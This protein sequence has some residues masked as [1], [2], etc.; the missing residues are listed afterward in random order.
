M[1]SSRTLVIGG[2]IMGACSA[3]FL[4]EPPAAGEVIVLERDPSYQ[5]ASTTLS[6]A[7]IRTQFSL[8]VNVRMSLFGDQFQERLD[9]KPGGGISRVRRGYLTLAGPE[10]EAQLRANHAM[11]TEEGA[12]VEWLDRDTLARTRPWLNVEDL[13]CGTYGRKHEGWCDAYALLRLT[14]AEAIEKGAQFRADEAVA[15]ERVGD[16]VVAVQTRSGERIEGD[17]VVIAAG[18]ASGRVAAMAGLALPVEPR[19]RTVF[20]IRTPLPTTDMPLVFDTSGAWIRPEGDGFLCGISPKDGEPDP[21]PGD[22]F[23]PDMGMMEESVWPLLAHRI[24]ALEELRVVR[25]WAGHYELCTLDH[26]AVIG[27]HPE[28]A[29]VIFVAG[30]SGHGVQHGPA[31]GRA[32]AEL[33]RTGG[34]R[35]L[36]LSALGY[37]RVRENR[38]MPE[39]AVY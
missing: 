18:P 38:P 26:N 27:P 37:A 3:W 21:P 8:A 19:K 23:E 30:F 32:V 34:F 13:V 31:A 14:R 22:D 11:Q 10:G 6:A 36:D 39:L 9:A 7:G 1:A 16:R 29:N 35:T 5:R 4:R 12:D 15:I 33:V 24:P 17:H 25:A 28:V 20:V 2:G